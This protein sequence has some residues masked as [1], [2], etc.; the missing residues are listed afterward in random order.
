MTVR[1]QCPHCRDTFE[2]ERKVRDH[3]ETCAERESGA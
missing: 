2:T 3:K 1:Y